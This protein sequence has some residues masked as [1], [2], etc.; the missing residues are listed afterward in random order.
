MWWIGFGC[1]GSF[2]INAGAL[3][4]PDGG[5]WYSI[6]PAT[7]P[8]GGSYENASGG[9]EYFLSASDFLGKGDTRVA[10]WALTNT[11]SLN[12]AA[13]NVSL[14]DT[15]VNSEAYGAP[16][17]FSATQK[18]GPTPLGDA[19]GGSLEALNAND[20][21]M[22]QVVF[23][24]GKL[25]SGL[26]TATSANT[27]AIAYFIVAPS[28]ASGTLAATMANQGYVAAS[29]GNNVLFPSVGVN[30]QGKGVIAFTLSGPDYYPSAAYTPIN[31]VSGVGAIT[32]SGAGVGPEDGSPDIPRTAVTRLLV[33][34]TTPRPLL[35]PTAQSGSPTSTLVKVAPTRSSRRI[36]RV[37]ARARLWLTGV[38]SSAM[39]SRKNLPR[40]PIACS[41]P[42]VIRGTAS[43]CT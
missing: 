38:P 35:V 39:C 11:S 24:N 36:Q 21:R 15:I 1:P 23:A 14:T 34:A 12:S 4:A 26:N 29:N 41:R 17:T 2:S 3:P 9:S 40:R 7:T 37:A 8:P 5:P 32:V 6:Q 16:L 22:N 28:E 25:W 19:V 27:V 30:A 18:A 31:G 13:P 20:D 10:A 42:V 43:L 33:G